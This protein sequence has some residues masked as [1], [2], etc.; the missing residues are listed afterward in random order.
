LLFITGCQSNKVNVDYDTEA[1]FAS[2]RYYQFLTESSGSSKDFDPL[3]AN[4]VKDALIELMPNTGMQAA[5]TEHSPDIRVRYFMASS[6]TSKSSNTR[7]SVGVGGGSG[8]GS[9]MMGMSMSIPLGGGSASTQAQI[10]VDFIGAKDEKLKWRG[11]QN[12]KFSDEPPQELNAMV[13]QV[14]ADIIAMYPPGKKPQ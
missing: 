3:M 8:G 6:T 7:G 13:K 5:G 2:Y 11:S 10:I 9:T 12:L 4:R 14:V 1:D